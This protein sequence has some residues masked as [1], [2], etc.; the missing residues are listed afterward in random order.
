MKEVLNRK[1][2]LILLRPSHLQMN[3]I[4]H[5]FLRVGQRPIKRRK[6]RD[7]RLKKKIERVK[8]GNRETERKLGV[9]QLG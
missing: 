1:L 2:M 7:W 8:K 4:L 3:L 6:Q 9:T 5:L